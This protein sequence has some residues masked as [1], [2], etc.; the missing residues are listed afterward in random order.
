M[1]CVEAPAGREG[2]GEGAGSGAPRAF[3]VAYGDGAALRCEAGATAF[4][5]GATAYDLL[6]PTER[7]R[8]MRT[9]VVYAAHP[10]KRFARCGMTRD[11]LRCVGGAEI[12]TAIQEEEREG[13]LRLVRASEI[14]TITAES[15]ELRGGS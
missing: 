11:G 10:F 1:R 15:R 4:C 3:D 9:T 7:A 13:A 8:A 12:E 6:T 5:S 2:R 14:Q